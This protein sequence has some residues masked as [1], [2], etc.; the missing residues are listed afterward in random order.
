M[1]YPS[2]HLCININ[3][4]IMINQSS[5]RIS[6]MKE[7]M[8]FIYSSTP[9]LSLPVHQDSMAQHR[10]PIGAVLPSISSTNSLP[11]ILQT[12]YPHKYSKRHPNDFCKQHPMNNAN[13]TPL[14]Q[15][16]TPKRILQ[17]T[18]KWTLQTAP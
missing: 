2:F 12:A 8:G 4:S 6:L 3:C 5:P 1:Y 14:I 7:R 17:T 16:V 9:T 13:S 18:S 10:E 11:K 15:K